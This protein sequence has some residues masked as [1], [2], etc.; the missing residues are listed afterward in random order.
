MLR[1]SAM[2]E[3][4]LYDANGHDRQIELSE[5]SLDGLVDGQLLWID[6]ERGEGEALR[7]AARLCG[8][9]EGLCD[10]LG[11][12]S[13]LHQLQRFAT[14]FQFAVTL[15][16]EHGEPGDRR[17]DFLI[18]K[19]W[20][21]TVRDGEV[22]FLTDF[23]TRDRAETEIGKLSSATLAAS[24]LDWHLEAYF[25]AMSQIEAS[26]DLLDEASLTERVSRNGLRRLAALRRRVSGLRRRLAAQRG[27]FHGLV[28]PD[29]EPVAGAGVLEHFQQ[30]ESRFERAVD[31]IDSS[32]AAVAGAFE[33]FTSQAAQE[34]N[35][36]VKRL[37]FVTVI[38][39]IAGAVSGIFGMNFQTEFS[40]TGEHG[41]H[42]VIGSMIIGSIV[43][44]LAARR[45]GWI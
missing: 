18:G 11:D 25:S 34:T 23:R 43:A 22:P 5:T 45:K 14:H 36:L 40:R 21:L 35:D 37:T 6:I 13:A 8:I 41:F 16:P 42:L 19:S 33:L 12:G 15:A 20:L 17:L 28:R 39:G 30:V 27:V 31:Q 32:R 29:F 1:Y 2:A 7:A 38:I 24:L 4:Y 44:T 3:T 10:E 26:V 9:E